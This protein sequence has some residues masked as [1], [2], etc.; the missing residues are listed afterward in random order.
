MK[1]LDEMLMKN[2][3]EPSEHS[4]INPGITIAYEV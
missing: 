4:W 1:Q 3:F 2:V